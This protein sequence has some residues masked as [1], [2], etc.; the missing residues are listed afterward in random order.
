M[1]HGTA[2]HEHTMGIAMLFESLSRPVAPMTC[3]HRGASVPP[4]SPGR[5]QD[6]LC[7]RETEEFPNVSGSARQDPPSAHHH[8]DWIELEGVAPRYP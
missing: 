4:S 3:H 7:Q 1:I 8:C 5:V 6:P 2:V